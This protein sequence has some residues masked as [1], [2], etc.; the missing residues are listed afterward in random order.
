MKNE[1]FKSILAFLMEAPWHSDVSWQIWVQNALLLCMSWNCAIMV[2]FVVLF[3]TPYNINSLLVD[4]GVSFKD[5]AL[6]SKVSGGRKET[7]DDSLSYKWGERVLLQECRKNLVNA[8]CC[9]FGVAAS[10]VRAI[11]PGGMMHL[12]LEDFQLWSCSLAVFSISQ[13]V[14]CNSL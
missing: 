10:V 7:M 14:I 5:Q 1:C 13:E 4:E 9:F 8:W 11:T 6:I 3:Y 2:I 12:A